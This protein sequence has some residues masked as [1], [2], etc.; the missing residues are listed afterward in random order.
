MTLFLRR[1]YAL[2]WLTGAWLMT[3]SP[4]MAENALPGP[5]I[6]QIAD[7]TLTL[8]AFTVLPDATTSSLSV[9]QSSRKDPGVSISTLSGGATWS[10]ELPL[11]LE[12]TLGYTRYTPEFISPDGITFARIYWDSYAATGGIGW[13]V[14]LS[15]DRRWVVRPILNLT[16]GH[17]DTRTEIRQRPSAYAA[18]IFD[19]GR[20]QA[21]GIG[22]ALMLDYRNYTAAQE[23]DLELR[24]T[25]INL[26]TV[27]TTQEGLR[28]NSHA[29]AL[30]GWWRYRKPSGFEV[31]QRP[32]RMVGEISAS[33]FFGP[34]RK[35]LGFNHLISIGTG[36]E[37]DLSAHALYLQRART[38]VRFLIGENVTG[39]SLGLSLSF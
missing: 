6:K 29:Q 27:G 31:W 32:L 13:D 19:G 10:D 28:G 17:V 22:G 30:S 15:E 14:P 34:Q 36:V 26:A 5:V 16:L 25:H 11:Y 2:L 39:V 18:P 1:T 35:A 33:S 3:L 38:L 7:A 21:Y 24:L 9:E 37:L 23:V 20:M 4:A 12:G 8:M